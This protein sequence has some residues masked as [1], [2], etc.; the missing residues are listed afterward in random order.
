MY[1]LTY[2]ILS[3]IVVGIVMTIFIIPQT[4]TAVTSTSGDTTINTLRIFGANMGL[5]DTDPRVIVARLIRV[6]MGFVGIILLLM[7]L[8]SGTSFLISGGDEEKIKSAKRT[9]FNAIIGVFIILSA[10]SI[11]AFILNTLST[12]NN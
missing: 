2:K 5:P 6:A 1:K 9:L 7:I 12:A 11:T 10:Y 4:A 8:S 3:L